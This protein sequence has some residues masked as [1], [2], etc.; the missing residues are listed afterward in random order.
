MVLHHAVINVNVSFTFALAFSPCLGVLSPCSAAPWHW[1]CW[2]TSTNATRLI[3]VYNIIVMTQLIVVIII[4][5]VVILVA[6]VLNGATIDDTAATNKPL[7]VC[8]SDEIN[9]LS[10]YKGQLRTFE[11]HTLQCIKV[12]WP[13]VGQYHVRFET[14]TFWIWQVP[15]ISLP[16]WQQCSSIGFMTAWQQC[17]QLK[18]ALPDKSNKNDVLTMMTMMTTTTTTWFHGIKT[19]KKGSMHH[20][21][22]PSS[23]SSLTSTTHTR[24]TCAIPL[25]LMSSPV[26]TIPYPTT[27][28]RTTTD[29]LS[30]Q[31]QQP[32]S[33]LSQRM[34]FCV[35]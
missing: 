26:A 3:V 25:S 16:W 32:P 33:Q 31:Q 2:H 34:Q 35:F 27:P 15:S 30:Q 10:G 28:A 9:V 5:D 19:T 20:S 11:S 29:G 1:Q 21:D 12:N 8:F 7:Q 18:N 14:G 13:V 23:L 17:C 24:L 22:L 6:S 4:I